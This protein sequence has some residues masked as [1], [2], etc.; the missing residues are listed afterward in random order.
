MAC[1]DSTHGDSGVSFV[2]VL[3]AIALSLV[4]VSTVLGMV[5]A[6]R[7]AIAST[8]DLVDIQQRLRA[9]IAAIAREVQAAGAGPDGGPMVGPLGDYLPPVIP[10][11]IGAVAADPARSARSDVLSLISVPEGVAYP[12]VL[13]APM[14]GSVFTLDERR[15]PAGRPA[16]GFEPGMG[17][18]VF[19]TQQF[20]LFNI[21]NI[22]GNLVTVRPRGPSSSREY[23][24]GASIAPIVARTYYLDAVTRTLREYDTD[25]TDSPVIDDAVEL[26]FEFAGVA[27]PPTRPK[28]PPGRANCLYD[29]AGVATPGLASLEFGRSG[30]AEL[31]IGL[32]TDG[33]W[34]GSGALE[35]DADLLRVRRVRITLGLRA[36]RSA[37]SSLRPPAEASVT[38]D[39]AL[40]NLGS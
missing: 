30:L 23:G 31:P 19:D 36:A 17:A 14:T 7:P 18:V 27:G 40:R 21:Q 12:T 39:I 16:C 1:S 4:V 20:D 32:F 38:L 22:S 3:V 35:F 13:A 10:R 26:R 33:P 9:G 15:C 6:V 24:D 29:E 11:R 8:P 25:Q 5:H 34:C 28:P 37:G 2:E